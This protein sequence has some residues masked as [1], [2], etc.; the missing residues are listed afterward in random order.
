MEISGRKIGMSLEPK[1]D[2]RLESEVWEFLAYNFKAMKLD[3]ISCR[4]RMEK[5]RCLRTEYWGTLT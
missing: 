1:R 3:G 4:V 5:R 2:V